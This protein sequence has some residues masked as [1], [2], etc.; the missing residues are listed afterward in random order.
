MKYIVNLLKKIKYAK[1]VLYLFALIKM[2]C[3]SVF[4]LNILPK[5]WD[6]AELV[7]NLICIFLIKKGIF[8]YNPENDRNLFSIDT[9]ITLVQNIFLSKGKEDDKK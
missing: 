5:Q 2:V 3:T 4:H 8:E 7:L 6:V 1:Q 9:Y